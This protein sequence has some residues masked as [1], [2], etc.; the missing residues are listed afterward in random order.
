MKVQ[1]EW[2]DSNISQT[3]QPLMIATLLVKKRNTSHTTSK[4][5]MGYAMMTVADVFAGTG[6]VHL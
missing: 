3:Y 5:E 2:K 1:V 4:V 6:P